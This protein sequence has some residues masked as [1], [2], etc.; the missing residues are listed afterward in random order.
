MTE[1]SVDAASTKLAR[2]EVGRPALHSKRKA[3]DV[4]NASNSIMLHK[5]EKDDAMSC[6]NKITDRQLVQAIE[7]IVLKGEQKISDY[8]KEQFQSKT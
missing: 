2:A 5:A 8:G 6:G 4:Y 7:K 3:V 1:C